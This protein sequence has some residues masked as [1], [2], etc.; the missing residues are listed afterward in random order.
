MHCVATPLTPPELRTLRAYVER[1]TDTLVTCDPAT[2]DGLVERGFA[3]RTKR[4]VLVTPDGLAA[5]LD[6][7]PASV[8][9]TASQSADH[10]PV[11]PDAPKPR[12]KARRTSAV[13]SSRRS[14][15]A[16]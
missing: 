15:A 3:Q 1:D 8:M 6:V 2:L 12:S 13:P 9:R 5:V 14:R 4:G 10:E 7:V 16:S 11:T